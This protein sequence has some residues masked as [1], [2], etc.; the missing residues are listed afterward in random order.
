Q[1]LS[2]TSREDK[3]FSLLNLASQL[4]AGNFFF[5]L[6]TTRNEQSPR[7]FHLAGRHDDVEITELPQRNITIKDCG[8]DWPFIGNCRTLMLLEQIQYLESSADRKRLRCCICMKSLPEA[9]HGPLGNEIRSDV[10][11]RLIKQW[12]TRWYCAVWIRKS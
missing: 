6:I 3:V 10:T 1:M 4:S 9:D 5:R 7:F 8:K 12:M 2:H 11:E